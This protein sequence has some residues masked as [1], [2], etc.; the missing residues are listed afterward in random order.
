MAV[1][2][3]NTRALHGGEIWGEAALGQGTTFYFTPGCANGNDEGK[4]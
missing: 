2:S 1:F 4:K 3:H